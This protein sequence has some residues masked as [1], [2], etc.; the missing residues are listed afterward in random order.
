MTSPSS[1]EFYSV[2][3]VKLLTAKCCTTATEI[4]TVHLRSVPKGDTLQLTAA[5]HLLCRHVQAINLA[6]GLTQCAL[7]TCFLHSTD[8]QMCSHL[9][10]RQLQEAASR[11]ASL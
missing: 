5:R 3:S 2:Q 4:W 9:L 10:R 11:G 1:L 8:T 6:A 7:V